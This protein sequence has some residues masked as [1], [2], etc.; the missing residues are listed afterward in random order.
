MS[1]PARKSH[2]NA[3]RRGQQWTAEED[4]RLT[5]WLE[6]N[7]T[8]DRSMAI[9]LQRTYGA[10]QDRAGYLRKRCLAPPVITRISA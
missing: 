2:R 1:L 3:R 5:R 7:S 10:V 9:A 6:G 8:C 4:S